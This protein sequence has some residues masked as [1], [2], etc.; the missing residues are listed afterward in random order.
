MKVHGVAHHRH[1]VE[2]EFDTLAALGDDR[3]MFTPA[4]TIDC[5]DIG[6]HGSFQHHHPAIGNRPFGQ[7]VD[8]P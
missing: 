3:F 7:R 1:V 6:R 5:P 8:S 2:S 4:A